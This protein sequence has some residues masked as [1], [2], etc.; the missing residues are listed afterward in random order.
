MGYD[1]P[2]V[3]E[4]EDLE[5]AIKAARAALQ[6][7]VAGAQDPLYGANQHPTQREWATSPQGVRCPLCR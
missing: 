5:S 1:L 6:N 4:G 2:T 3:G 7:I